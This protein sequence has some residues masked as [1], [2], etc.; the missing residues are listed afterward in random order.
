M[1]ID[2]GFDLPIEVDKV[3]PALLDVERVAPCL[4]G[5]AITGQAADGRF[6]GVMKVKL[7]PVRSAFEGTLQI[8]EADEAARRIV[9][10][11]SARDTSGHGAAAATI[12]S[13][14]EPTVSGTH[15]SFSTELTLAGTAGQFGRAVVEDVSRK[16]VREFAT[17]LAAEIEHPADR[18]T[19]V[20]QAQPRPKVTAAGS[21]ASNPE[22]SDAD[23]LDL[24]AAGRDVLLRRAA[25]LCLGAVALSIVLLGLGRRRR[26]SAPGLVV[27][28][29]LLVVGRRAPKEK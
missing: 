13:V 9:L 28:G 25:P 29:P 17:R 27:N 12:T 15:V 21:A 8:T 7:G 4:P 23:V 5:A 26:S 11:A 2:S 22:A 1:L 24:T 18:A 20:R 14:L 10:T 3:W 16:L 19:P 6:Q